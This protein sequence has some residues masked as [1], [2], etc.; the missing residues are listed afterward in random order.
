MKQKIALATAY[1]QLKSPNIKTR[2]RALQI[3][4]AAKRQATGK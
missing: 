4:R 1:R 2:E 3:I